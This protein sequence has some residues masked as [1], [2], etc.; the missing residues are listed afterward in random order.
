LH[1]PVNRHLVA[2]CGNKAPWYR[3]GIR[4]GRAIA[5]D[6]DGTA[7]GFTLLEIMVSLSILAIALLA[8]FRLQSQTLAMH[9]RISFDAT[10]PFLAQAQLAQI[11]ARFPNPPENGAGDW[12]RQW[13]GYSWRARV[14]PVEIDELGDTAEDF[15][16][17]DITVFSTDDDQ[18]YQLTAYRFVR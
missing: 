5:T 7:S 15:Y 17:I 3:S 12:G 14:A 4:C 6:A 13:P 18:D 9:E 2:A 16:R 1:F 10:A 11:E 8:V